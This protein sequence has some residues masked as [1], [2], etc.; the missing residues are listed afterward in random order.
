[1]KVSLFTTQNSFGRPLYTSSYIL[2]AHEIEKEKGKL[3]DCM[4]AMQGD[5]SNGDEFCS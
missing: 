3:F 4:H 5:L 2:Q 1:M